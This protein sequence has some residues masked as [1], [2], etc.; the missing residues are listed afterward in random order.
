MKRDIVKLEEMKPFVELWREY[1]DLR[2]KA[3]TYIHDLVLQYGK[4]TDKGRRRFT[5]NDENAPRIG[6]IR[7]FG[8]MRGYKTEYVKHIEVYG[9]EGCFV[10]GYMDLL[11]TEGEPI[12][13]M[14]IS[15]IGDWLCIYNAVALQV[16]KKLGKK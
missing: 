4:E 1:Q 8:A 10:M 7:A 3:C 15:S 16:K 12:E 2:Y 9:Y 11:N 5:L 6:I 13:Q 14:D